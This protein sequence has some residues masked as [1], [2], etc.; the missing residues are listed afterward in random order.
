MLLKNKIKN[1][2]DS[3]KEEVY[4]DFKRE[5]PKNKELLKDIISLANCQYE[6]DRY[7]I[8]GVEEIIDEFR[9][10]G[11]KNSKRKTQAELQDLLDNAHF[12]GDNIPEI[13]LE[14]I[15]LEDLKKNINEIDVI[16]IKDKIN[17]PYYLENNKEV[18]E[19]AV[20]TR[21]NDKNAIAT[22]S[23][24]KE[25]WKIQLGLN[26][27]DKENFMNYLRDYK[28]WEHNEDDNLFYYTPNSDYNIS[29]GDI[30]Y[31]RDMKE[32]FSKFYL[33]DT[34]NKCKASFNVRNTIIFSCEHIYCDGFGIQFPTPKLKCITYETPLDGFYY[35]LLDD[36]IGLYAKMLFE[37][38]N[39]FNCRFYEFPCIF[40][41]NEDELNDFSNFLN[42][43]DN[44]ID[45]Q[46]QYY[47]I[48]AYEDN[49]CFRNV[50]LNSLRKNKYI[51]DYYYL[52]HDDLK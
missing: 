42:D 29:L 27:N 31:S 46:P 32:P 1:L 52:P 7:L 37:M 14:T 44:E 50:D 4:Y 17:K 49:E 36:F 34:F 45:I 23:E 5:L 24:I 15:E 51:F 8:L 2:I 19:Y 47:P 16:I 18:K 6:G 33:D 41:N 11:L 43:F 21:H 35:Y 48:G 9:V 25:M 40:F 38:F 3:N 20:W 28:N 22:Y 10:C 30:D 13:K 26:N 12:A 39:G